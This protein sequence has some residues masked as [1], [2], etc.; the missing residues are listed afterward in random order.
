MKKIRIACFF[1][2]FLHL[3]ITFTA[4]SASVLPKDLLGIAPQDETFYKAATIK[5]RDGSKKFTKLELNDD[6][7]DCADGTD[8]PGTSACPGGKF[9]C[10]N[11]GHTPVSIYSSRV[12]DGIC[13][14]CDGSDEYDGKINCTNSCWEAGKV[15]RDRLKKKITIYEEGLTL[16]K[17]DVEQSKIAYAKDEAELSKLKK[18]EYVLKGL[19]QQLKERK[20]QVEKAEEKERLQK[21]KEEEKKREAEKEENKEAENPIDDKIGV[22]DDSP[23]DDGTEVIDNSIPE[24]QT[25]Y[26]P[27]NE[28]SHNNDDT[29]K[30]DDH[31]DEEKQS[32]IPQ[33]NDLNT[34]IKAEDESENSKSLSREELGRIVGSRWTGKK[35][36]PEKEENLEDIPKE[37]ENDEYSNNNNGYDTELEDEHQKYDEDEHHKYDEHEDHVEED[38]EDE[39]EDDHVDSTT[40]YK[41]ES[42]SDDSSDYSDISST[43]NPT[44][45]ETIQTTVRKIV[46]AVNLFQTPIDKSEAEH[47]RKEYEESNAKLTKMQS[48]ISSLTEKLKKDFGPEKEFYSFYGRCLEIKQ[49]KYIYKICPYKKATQEE[50]HST[51]RLGNWE[52]FEDSYRIMHFSNGDKCW[53]GPDRSLKVRLRCGLKDEVTDVGEPSRCEYEALL[54]TPAVC[55]EAKL[56]ELQDKFNTMNKEQPMIHDEL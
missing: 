31:G 36:E 48:K 7:C 54:S 24:A 10:R 17:K 40:P 34:E 56:K 45:L 43:S 13:D 22:F 12:N 38:I 21:E 44:W 32:T 20:E 33:K 28:N 6:F 4:T 35:S 47:I 23:K 5:C 55:V 41:Y 16:R 18:E 8:E 30:Q 50:G 53:N 19:V 37:E 3:V 29:T 1:L 9:H 39:D 26:D 42:D 15:A 46:Q 27:A 14:C 25:N 2:F 51:T 49:N 11:A 52:K